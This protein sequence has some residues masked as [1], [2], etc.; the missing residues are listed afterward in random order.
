[1][2][3]SHDLTGELKK[4]P[5]GTYKLGDVYDAP[6]LYKAY[7][8]AKDISLMIN[9]RDSG[10]EESWFMIDKN[11]VEINVKKYGRVRPD[12]IHELQHYVQFKEGFAIG[13]NT[14][15]AIDLINS[16]S[17]DK[18][19]EIN[20]LEGKESA[21]SML[22]DIAEE[23]ELTYVDDLKSIDTIEDFLNRTTRDA[24]LLNSLL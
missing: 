17:P 15:T 9:V 11:A 5:N 16:L 12:L 20:I 21:M 6:E 3:P 10:A 7:P 13:G 14:G 22:S 1:M 23:S 24:N 18:L 2:F 4:V 19:R 8:E